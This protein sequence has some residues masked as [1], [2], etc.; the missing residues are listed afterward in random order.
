MLRFHPVPIGESLYELPA[1]AQGL[2]AIWTSL[3]QYVAKVAIEGGPYLKL[4][5]LFPPAF[6]NI[7]DSLGKLPH[8]TCIRHFTLDR[9]PLHRLSV[10]D[11]DVWGMALR[12]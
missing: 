5:G 1:L 11:S 3:S 12:G 7:L 2:A 10:E 9:H 4:A 6:Q 8:N